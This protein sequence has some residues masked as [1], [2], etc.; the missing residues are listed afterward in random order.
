MGSCVCN[1]QE[2]NG[3]TLLGGSQEIS[4]WYGSELKGSKN[5]TKV[6][7]DTRLTARILKNCAK[8]MPKLLDKKHN[9]KVIS[10]PVGLRPSST[11]DVRILTEKL[12]PRVSEMLMWWSVMVMVGVVSTTL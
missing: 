12:L 10:Q 2:G 1:S 11:G 8:I 9:F 5:E 3:N 7:P 6:E 4:N